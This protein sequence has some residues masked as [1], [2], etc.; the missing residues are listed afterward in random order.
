MPEVIRKAL[1][2][3]TLSIA[4]APGAAHAGEAGT[5]GFL[6]L[7][8]GAGARAAGMGDAFVALAD[9]ATATYWNPA[10]L[11]AVERTQFTLMHDE[12]LQSVRMETASIAHATSL[13]NFGIHF[14]GMY[15]DEIERF[16]IA[17]SSPTGSFNVYEIA[18][19]GA[20]GRRIAD[21]D[22]GVGVKGLHTGLDDLSA[23]GWA[24]DVGA[25]YR[26][27]IPGLTFAG[28]GQNLGPEMKFVEES[29]LLPAT[30]RVGASY[31]RAVPELRGDIAGEF[32]LVWPTDGDVRQHVGLEYMY[33][34]FASLR[35]GYKGNYDSQ[36]LTFGLGVRKSGYHFDYAFSDISNDLGHG[37]KFA[38]S[39]DL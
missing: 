34:R 20:Y 23:S 38:F 21:W 33:Q 14:S 10:G 22:V 31:E 26:T 8:L 37:H 2:A 15:L 19:T 9:D 11:A 12:W 5:A 24:V 28:A 27:R 25:R 17:S 32:D 13:G 39:V 35:V 3:C 6:S 30:G 16:E 29:F 1:V 18:V 4:L 36:G 7:R